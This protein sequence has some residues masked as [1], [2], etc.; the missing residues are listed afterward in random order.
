MTR[1]I[2]TICLALLLL[3]AKSPAHLAEHLAKSITRI[4]MSGPT[5]NWGT[6]TAF[7][8]DQER[9]WGITAGHCV[10]SP[11]GFR[12]TVLDEQKRPLHVIATSSINSDLALLKGEIF[13]S[14]PQL[15]ALTI[16]PAAGI[17][18]GAAG[19][20]YGHTPAFFI[21]SRIAR[22]TIV[23]FEM[24]LSDSVLTGMSGAPVATR[25]GLIVGVITQGGTGYTHVMGSW[26]FQELYVK[27][28]KW[29]NAEKVS[30]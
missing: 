22:S 7:V 4:H 13:T 21:L 5:H 23:H 10:T 2:V 14:L 3:G 9:G 29:E 25:D 6:C 19:F 20:A 12:F 8:I 17:E 24:Q 18:V 11:N 27:G 16:P 28:L 1:T 26:H 30:P 15:I